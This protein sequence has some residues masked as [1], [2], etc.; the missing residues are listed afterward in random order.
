MVCYYRI[1][2]MR[3]AINYIL[4]ILLLCQACRGVKNPSLSN[5]HGDFNDLADLKYQDF[6]DS[7]C[8]LDYG[9]LLAYRKIEDR[10]PKGLKKRKYL[11]N[12]A[13]LETYLGNYFNAIKISDLAKLEPTEMMVFD[14]LGNMTPS[15]FYPKK[16]FND[17]PDSL[18]SENYDQIKYADFLKNLNDTVRVFALNEVHTVPVFR[19]ILYQS[20]TDLRAKGFKYLALE[21]LYYE[22][23]GQVNLDKKPRKD[24]GFFNGEITMGD[25]MRRAKEMDFELI[26]YD[27]QGVGSQSK[28][29][30]L[31]FQNIIERTLEK[32]PNSKIIL[33]AGHSHIAEAKIG[34]IKN[35][36]LQ[37][38]EY[39]IDPLTINQTA[40]YE[41]NVSGL[42]K[43]PVLFKKLNPEKK[44]RYDYMLVLPRSTLESGRPEWLWE[45]GRKP[46]RLKRKKI[47]YSPPLILEA[48]FKNDPFNTVPFDR[49]E[50]TAWKEMPPLALKKGDYLIRVISSSNHKKTFDLNVE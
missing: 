25:V 44:N 22:K 48:Y 21:T 3:K 10:I 6:F 38:R 31:S 18:F 5:A 41:R 15:V 40:Y 49:V 43:E 12:L 8:D 11:S 35:L 39:G 20:L 4:V 26:A 30:L 29:E 23:Q 42:I 28:R 9:K 1:P 33:F 32:D 37:F 50:V 45:M 13:L 17:F 36:G 19:K 7:N 34:R 14:S 2:K 24:L 16:A 47:K 27:A 46:V